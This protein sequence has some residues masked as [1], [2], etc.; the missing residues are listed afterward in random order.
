MRQMKAKLT[1]EKGFEHAQDE[2]IE[3]LIYHRIW[4]SATCWKTIGAVV[5]GL[6]KL[7][8]KKNKLGE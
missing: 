1:R 5:E 2:F 4:S 8:Y 7:K 3:A 6:K